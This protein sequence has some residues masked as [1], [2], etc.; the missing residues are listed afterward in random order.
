MEEITGEASTPE[1]PTGTVHSESD[2]GRE[3]VEFEMARFVPRLKYRKFKG[4]G[5]EDV[6]EWLCEFNATASANQEEDATKLRL[7]QGL[8][9][10]EALQWYQEVP[11][12]VRNDWTQLTE[13]FLRTFR[14]VGGEARTLGKLSK[15]KMESDESV[16]RYG[17]RVRSL[18]HKL[19]SG[20]AASVQVEWY[21]AG[22][23]D[24][25]GFQV[26]QARPQTLQEAM[27][28]AQN[29]ENSMQS[30]RQSRRHA[31]DESWKRAKKIRRA[32][33]KAKSTSSDSSDSSTDRSSGT[34]T[35]DSEDVEEYRHSRK[36]S[37]S[38]GHRKERDRVVVKV[39]EELPEKKQ[40]MK[41][42]QSSLAAIK[43]H[44]ADNNKARRTL[45]STRN[46][47]WCIRCGQAGHYPNECPIVPPK[48]VQYVNAEGG[49]FFAEPEYEEDDP[50]VMPVY[51]VNPSYGQGRTPQPAR[52]RYPSGNPASTVYPSGMPR[53]PSN[54]RPP[55]SV[56]RQFGL[57]Y[58]CG[59]HGHYASGCPRNRAGQ[60]APL[61]LPCQNCGHYGHKADQCQQ[62]QKPRV[63]Y[64]QVE[65]PP[66]EKTGLNY[67]HQEGI[68]NP[69]S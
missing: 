48:R 60:A 13:S 16:R 3:P 14:E 43:V 69:N 51:Q 17:Q 11:A 68:A 61:E 64:K 7:F 22:L 59:E 21:V 9:K 19:N 40:M 15:M 46:N 49:V 20:I 52:P 28:S 50:E 29:Y 56:E 6:D 18:I 10:K 2:S 8:L 32:R 63:V 4:D 37:G 35:S 25:M 33:E 54:V 67:G 58:I 23:P 53:A 44:L 66:R 45:P 26:R 5:R 36:A 41:D 24:R 47:V 1:V 42:I 34:E 55:V 39:K 30:L 65:V 38:R 57:C 31:T 27:E 62:E 12:P